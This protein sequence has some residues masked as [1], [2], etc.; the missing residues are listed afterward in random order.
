M[1]VGCAC[2]PYGFGAGWLF[3]FKSLILRGERNSCPPGL[4]PSAWSNHGWQI[5][6][7]WYRGRLDHAAS[8]CHV[9]GAAPP[10]PSPPRH[11]LNTWVTVLRNLSVKQ[12]SKKEPFGLRNRL[13]ENV[14]T[15]LNSAQTPAHLYQITVAV[16]SQPAFLYMIPLTVQQCPLIMTCHFWI[17][18]LV[19]CWHR[20]PITHMKVRPPPVIGLLNSNRN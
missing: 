14:N 4:F 1:R 8:Y 10:L 7:H 19:I 16:M 17:G 9:V 3:L 11:I 12:Q 2:R 20:M 5:S 18:V 6:C 13:K 15:I